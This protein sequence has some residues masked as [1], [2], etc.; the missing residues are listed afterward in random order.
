MVATVTTTTTTMTTPESSSHLISR[1]KQLETDL[2]STHIH[3][4]QLLQSNNKMHAQASIYVQEIHSRDMKIEELKEL[5]HWYEVEMGKV[6]ITSVAS[7][8]FVSGN[9]SL[10]D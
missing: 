2:E 8:T 5:V 4:M 10:D 9:E 1:I 6:S 7:D 3:A